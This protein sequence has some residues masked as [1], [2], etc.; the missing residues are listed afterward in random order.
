M[1]SELKH[2]RLFK[3]KAGEYNSLSL[4]KNTPKKDAFDVKSSIIF[5]PLEKSNR[6]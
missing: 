2:T 4:S 5:Y 6:N 1:W 3:S